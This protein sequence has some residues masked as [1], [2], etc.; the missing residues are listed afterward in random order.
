[1][2][3]IF[4]D[5]IKQLMKEYAETL[6]SNG[7]SIIIIKSILHELINESMNEVMLEVNCDKD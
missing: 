2:S 6:C 5:N 1:M 4:K 7:T 3:T